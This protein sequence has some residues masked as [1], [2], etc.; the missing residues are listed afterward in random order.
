MALVVAAAGAADDGASARTGE[1]GGY[2]IRRDAEVAEEAP[3]PH[4]GLGRTTGHVFFDDVPGRPFSFRKRVLHPGA[5][6]GLHEQHEDE[7]YYVTSGGGRMTIDGTGFDVKAGD[8]VLTRPGSSH[9]L[10]QAGPADL[11]VV[12]VFART[13]PRSP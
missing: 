3:G 10:V 12:I 11:V 13:S 8:A 7:V 5:S 9:G 2:L 1:P 6:I 4:G